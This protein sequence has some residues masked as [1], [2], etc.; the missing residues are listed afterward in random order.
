MNKI[1]LLI[2]LTLFVAG[3]AGSQGY[4]R[5]YW[6]AESCRAAGGILFC[7]ENWGTCDCVS[8]EAAQRALDRLP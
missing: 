3:C 1:K 2:V 4:Q 5:P 8:E 6:T 7:E